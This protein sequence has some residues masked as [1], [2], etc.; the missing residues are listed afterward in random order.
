MWKRSLMLVTIRVLPVPLRVFHWRFELCHLKWI[1]FHFRLFFFGRNCDFSCSY[2]FFPVLFLVPFLSLLL[3]CGTH[4]TH[5]DW[6]AGS[7]FLIIITSACEIKVML[8]FFFNKRFINFWLSWVFVAVRRPA[9]GTAS[10]ATPC[11]GGRASHCC[12]FSCGAWAELP[13]SKWD[14]P[15]P[16]F[17]LRTPVLAGGFLTTGPQEARCWFFNTW[18]INS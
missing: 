15:R 10:R 8:D 1:Y 13:R 6:L 9:L 7:N 12:G 11:Q 14:L 18:N 3:V 17:K 2:S 5:L 16:G 4:K